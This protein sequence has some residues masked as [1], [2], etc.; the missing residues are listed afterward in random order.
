MEVKFFNNIKPGVPLHPVT[1]FSMQ[2][3]GITFMCR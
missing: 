2:E 3:E 1:L